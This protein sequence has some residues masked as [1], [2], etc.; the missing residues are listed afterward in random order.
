M[1]PDRPFPLLAHLLFPN[2]QGFPYED[3]ALTS[4]TPVAMAIPRIM[5]GNSMETKPMMARGSCSKGQ[6]FHHCSGQLK[7]YCTDGEQLL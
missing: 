5:K 3:P 2:F 1:F 6:C 7:M 4:T